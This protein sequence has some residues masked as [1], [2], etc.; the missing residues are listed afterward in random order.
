V[1]RED[2]NVVYINQDRILNS[3]KGLNADIFLAGGTGLHRFVL[4]RA[5]RHSEDLDFFFPSLF[6]NEDV[7]TVVKQITDVIRSIPGHPLR[8]YAV[9]KKKVLIGFGVVLRIMMR[10]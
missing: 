2:W 4:A 5:Y 1:H 6:K 10:L 9:S 3:L 7:A 8:R